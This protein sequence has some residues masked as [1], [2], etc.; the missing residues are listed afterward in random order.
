MHGGVP[1]RCSPV[2]LR[3]WPDPATPEDLCVL[4]DPGLLGGAWGVSQSWVLCEGW[5][6]PG[7]TRW[8]WLSAHS[9][10]SST[11]RGGEASGPRETWTLGSCLGFKMH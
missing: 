7:G 4:M 3:V 10:V 11:C 6:E 9:V 2:A 5:G 1:G 8:P